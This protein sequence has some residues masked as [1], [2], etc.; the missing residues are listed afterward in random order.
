[1]GRRVKEDHIVTVLFFLVSGEHPSLPFS[2][3]KAILE[4]EG[5]SYKVLEELTQVLRVQADIECLKAVKLRASMMRAGGIEF[6]NCRAESKEILK[7]AKETDFSAFLDASDSFAVRVKRVR[8]SSPDVDSL[9]L[10]R[11]IGEIIYENVEGSKVD[12]KAPRKNFFGILTDGRFIFGLK[13]VQIKAGKFVERGSKEK[14]FT[15]SAEMPPKIARCMVN[16]AQAKPGDLMLD[17]FCGTG[18]FLV[19]A[20]LIGCRVLGFDVLRSMVEGSLRNLARYEVK[21]EGLAV[22]DTRHLPLPEKSVDCVATDPPYGTSST[23]LGLSRKDVFETFLATISRY[24]KPG[25]RICLAAPKTVGVKEIGER[26]GFKH[27]Q[28]HLIYVHRSLTREIAVF[29]LPR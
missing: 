9:E 6:F 27:L 17:P 21:L 28:S 2:E 16:L 23:T 19:E 22:A 26:I 20:G 7:N 29:E 4:A 15:H 5:F 8:G 13:K 24:I 1:M 25:R 18:S 14:V 12:L 10:E 11:R 3:T